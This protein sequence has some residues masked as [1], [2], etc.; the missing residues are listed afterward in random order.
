MM[1]GVE[2]YLQKRVGGPRVLFG[3]E[4]ASFVGELYEAMFVKG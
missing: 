3:N 2:G 4:L 1:G